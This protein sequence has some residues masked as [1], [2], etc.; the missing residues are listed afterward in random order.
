[1]RS[2]YTICGRDSLLPRSM[3]I[4][5]GY[6]RL[7][8]PQSPGG[9]ADVWKGSHDG[10]DVAAKVLRVYSTSDFEKIRKVGGP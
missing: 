6:D 5:I 3:K 9:F 4:S 8:P 7:E 10:R 2:V 1:M